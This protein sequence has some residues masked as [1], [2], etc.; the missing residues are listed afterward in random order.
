MHTNLRVENL[1]WSILSAFVLHPCVSRLLF[2]CI[3]KLNV[4]AI[5][6]M[7]LPMPV[8]CTTSVEFRLN[9][10]HILSKCNSFY[11]IIWLLILHLQAAN[12]DYLLLQYNVHGHDIVASNLACDYMIW[13]SNEFPYHW[14]QCGMLDKRYRQIIQSNPDKVL[15]SVLCQSE[16][17]IRTRTLSGLTFLWPC[18]C[19][20]G[21]CNVIQ[22]IMYSIW[23]G[24]LNIGTGKQSAYHFSDRWLTTTTYIIIKKHLCCNASH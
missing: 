15:A 9:V 21:L 13:S 7:L 18:R 20:I 19:E 8:I 6:G 12:N 5:I 17:F 2:M 16:D 10:L 24:Y 14:M 22:C 4:V 3:R 1:Y 23:L 11:F